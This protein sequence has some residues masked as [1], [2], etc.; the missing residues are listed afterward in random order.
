[1]ASAGCT[2]TLD[3]SAPDVPLLLDLPDTT[4]FTKLNRAPMD[5]YYY[6]IGADGSYW[7]VYSEPPRQRVVRVSDPTDEEELPTD[8][9]INVTPLWWTFFTVT[10]SD[11]DDQ[12]VTLTIRSAGQK[13]PAQVYTFPPGPELLI[14]YGSGGEIFLY[15]VRKEDTKTFQIIQ[16]SGGSRTLDVPKG[17][18]PQNPQDKGWLQFNGAGDILFTRDADGRVVAHSTKI[19]KDVDLGV[20]PPGL[21]MDETGRALYYCDNAGLHSL[22]YD[23]TFEVILD[24]DPCSF[25]LSSQS[26]RNLLYQSVDGLRRVPLDGSGPPQYVL[27]STVQR[28]LTSHKDWGYVYSLVPSGQYVNNVGDGWIKGRQFMERGRQVSFSRDGKKLRWIERAAQLSGSGDL[29]SAPASGEA[30]PLVLAHNVRTYS[31]LSDGRILAVANYAFRGVQN[32][33]IVIDEAQRVAQVV[34]EGA[35]SFGFLPDTTDILVT[36][37]LG[38]DTFDLLRVPLPPARTPAKV[39][40]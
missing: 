35:D 23:G 24:P 4:R 11:S 38:T 1:M 15:W 10:H 3:G 8:K 40:S 7:M 27:P 31:E 12:P 33:I 2:F 18:D 20:R 29:L 25:R 14:P 22:G 13:T 17:L 19:D 6:V 28:L 39:G 30:A 5:D 26:G 32:R 34:A 36:R 37:L 16:R 21:R 9:H